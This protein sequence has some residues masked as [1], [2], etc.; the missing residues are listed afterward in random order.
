MVRDAVGIA[1][2]AKVNSVK[3]FERLEG[4]MG[5]HAAVLVVVVAAPGEGLEGEFQARRHVLHHAED[6]QPFRHDL[7]ADT[8]AGDHRNFVGGHHFSLSSSRHKFCAGPY[9]RR[10]AMAEA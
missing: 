6:F 9:R 10:V 4:V 2:G 5:H 7:L 3:G 8:V 1:D